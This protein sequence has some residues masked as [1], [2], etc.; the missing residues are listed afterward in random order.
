MSLGE[1][2]GVLKQKWHKFEG[3][4]GFSTQRH[5]RITMPCFALHNFIRGSN[6][7]DKEFGRCDI[8]EEYMPRA[9][10]ASA[11]THEGNDVE[12][13]NDVTSN[14]IWDMIAMALASARST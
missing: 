3:M 5:K 12:G 2:F 1:H 4:P 11:K 7:K 8:N 6:L 13:D 14:T 10:S 9:T